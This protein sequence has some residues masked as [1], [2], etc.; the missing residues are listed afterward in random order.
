MSKRTYLYAASGILLGV[1]A[2]VL[3]AAIKTRR[4]KQKQVE[5]AEATTF[6]EGTE[7]HLAQ[8]DPRFAKMIRRLL[9]ASKELGFSLKVISSY[10]DCPKQNALYQVGR[11]GIPGEKIITSARCG[12]SAHNHRLAVDVEVWKDGR[13]LP[14]YGEKGLWAQVGKLGQ[15]LGL[16]WGGAW[17]TFYDPVHFADP[18]W[19]KLER[20]LTYKP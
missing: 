6:D 4:R 20:S 9:I 14:R 1:T 5:K 19:R 7:K 13:K 3:V 16:E 17:R 12:Q 8:L 18:K 2:V 10:R 11:R 15:K